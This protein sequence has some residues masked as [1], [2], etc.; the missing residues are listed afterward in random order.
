[1]ANNESSFEQTFT[2]TFGDVAEN[3]AR[4]VKHGVMADRG[5]TREELIHVKRW[6][7]AKGAET[8]LIKLHHYLPHDNDIKKANKAWVLV[9]KKGVNLILNDNNGANNL[10]NEQNALQKDKKALMYGRVVSKHARHNL[11]FGDNAIAANYEVGQGT[12]VAFDTVPFTKRIRE[13]LG[14][15]LPTMNDLQ[16][17]GNYYYD[18][19]TC[20]IS[21]HGDSERLKVVGTRLGATIPLVY[22]W[23]HDNKPITDVISND[24]MRLDHGDI[25]I[26]SEKAVGNDWKKKNSYTL[27]H[28]A[29]SKKYITL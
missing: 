28:A 9:I 23:F 8:K 1:M 10:Y 3:H 15:I 11:C 22:C 24:D 27:R 25:Y 6:F 29:G 2:L 17:E 21:F 16:L 7:K 20:G 5:F 18:V 13:T 19:K 26:M 14:T 12:V 4:M